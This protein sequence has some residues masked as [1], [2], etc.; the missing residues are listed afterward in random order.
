MKLDNKV[1]KQLEEAKYLS[2]DNTWRYRAIIRI[3][4]QSYEKMKYWFYKEDIMVKLK[5]YED[6]EEYTMDN[7]K[8]DLDSL[9]TWKNLLALADSSKVKSIEEF[10]NKEFRYQLST[11]TIEIERMLI[12]LENMTVENNASLECTM[13]E[14]FKDD[15]NEINEIILKDNKE[16]YNWWKKLNNDFKELNQNYQDYV[17]RFYSPKSEEMMK[18]TEFLLYKEGF[19]NYLRDFIRGLQINSL[20]IKE[21]LRNITDEDID[22]V[23]EGA[24]QYE[25]IIAAMEIKSEEFKDINLGRFASIKEWF[26]SYNNRAPLIEQLIDNTNEIIR[27]I[28]RFA[29]QIADKRGNSANRKE[30]YRKLANMFSKVSSIEEA[31]KLSALSFG[32]FCP[33]HIKANPIRETESINSSM[34]DEEPTEIILKP[35]IRNYREK[36]L[37]NPIEDKSERKKEKLRLIMEKRTKEEAIIKRLIV[38]NE[39]DFMKLPTLSYKERYVILRWLAKGQVSKRKGAKT[40]FGREYRILMAGKDEIKLKC[41]DGIFTM[42]HYIIKFEE[43][44]NG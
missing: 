43:Q 14:R 37:K 35:R 8:S 27:R 2:T 18:T 31:H 44:G 12:T 29:A 19:I 38:D 42:P 34:Y 33:R 1:R 11:Y 41:E 16:I 25:R 10:K 30:E 9:T 40:E 32:V 24:Y 15:L 36:M 6:F 17:S 23:I 26:L 4:Y 21:I 7:L 39:I 28:T 20:M 22:K 5:E 13:V 3:M